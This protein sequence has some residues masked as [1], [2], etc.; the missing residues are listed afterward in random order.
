MSVFTSARCFD[1][2]SR[3]YGA[4]LSAESKLSCCPMEVH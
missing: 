3:Q 2:A 4:A 1:L